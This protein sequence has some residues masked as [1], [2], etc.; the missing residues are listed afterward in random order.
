MLWLL[1]H[2]KFKQ[3][4]IEAYGRKKLEFVPAL[5]IEKNLKKMSDR[6]FYE[7]LITYC[8]LTPFKLKRM[9][10]KDKKVGKVEHSIQQILD[11]L[12]FIFA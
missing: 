5:T 8:T 11:I 1:P 10:E 4:Q 9:K 2:S 3:N 6:S 7:W 12:G